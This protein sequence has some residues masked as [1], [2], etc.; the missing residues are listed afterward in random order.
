[1][2]KCPVNTSSRYS[3]FL[4]YDPHI[5]RKTPVKSKFINDVE[6]I[7]IE[8]DSKQKSEIELKFQPQI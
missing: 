4:N 6:L 1:M 2:T 7:H 5:Q 8:D 3:L